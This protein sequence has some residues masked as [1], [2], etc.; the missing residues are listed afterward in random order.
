MFEGKVVIIT[1]A[2]GGI[3]TAIAHQ[4]AQKGAVLVLTDIQKDGLT[5]LRKNLQDYGIHIHLYRHDVSSPQS[6]NEV[7]QSVV[8]KH[9]KID[10]L[11]NNAG[12]VQPGAADKISIKKI[13]QQVSVN[14]LGTIYGCRAVLQVMKKQNQGHIVNVA[15][16]GGI[17]PM[18]G[19]AVY[20]AT[21]YAIRGY[22]LSLYSELKDTPVGISVI[23]PD[24]VDTPQ[25]DY[26]MQFDESS[27]SFLSVPLEPEVVAR[28]VPR[29]IEK[30][31]PEVLVPSFTGV[32]TRMGMGIPQIFFLLIPRLQKM[33]AKNRVKRQKKRIHYDKD[34]IKMDKTFHSSD[35]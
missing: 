9:G 4:F 34:S 26:E 19:E 33:G 16:L 25:L 5:A 21:K 31:K 27:L 10:I 32:L 3:G 18:P 14:L 35:Q 29:A 2:A 7:I 23:C 6:W 30:R 24:S 12:V 17:V 1:G 8:K 20:C 28:A 22:S 15:S 11:I 13:N